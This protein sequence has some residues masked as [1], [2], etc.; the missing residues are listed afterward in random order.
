M[1][2]LRNVPGMRH[3]DIPLH[4]CPCGCLIPVQYRFYYLVSSGIQEGLGV[5]RTAYRVFSAACRVQL[6]R[7]L[8]WATARRVPLYRLLGRAGKQYL[9]HLVGVP[10]KGKG[11]LRYPVKCRVAAPLPNTAILRYR[12]NAVLLPQ[13]P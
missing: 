4:P 8:P 6:Y 7:G 2:V 1:A 9:G 3:V 12:L 10:K 13:M 5:P 11:I